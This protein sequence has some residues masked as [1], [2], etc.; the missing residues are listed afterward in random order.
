M[1]NRWLKS[2]MRGGVMVAGVRRALR[3]EWATIPYG[4]VS[5]VPDVIIGG[6]MRCGTTAI[7]DALRASNQLFL[8]EVKEPHFY[9]SG[10]SARGGT[11]SR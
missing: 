10:T 5:A 3:N 9:A 4:I 2:V 1:A 8:S 6:F 11:R 7:Y